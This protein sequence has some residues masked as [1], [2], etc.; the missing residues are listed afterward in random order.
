MEPKRILYVESAESAAA[1][2]TELIKTP[3]LK[4]IHF[5]YDSSVEEVPIV[6]YSIER[7]V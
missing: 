5:E 7:F 1:L 2:L 3:K 6:K 4:A